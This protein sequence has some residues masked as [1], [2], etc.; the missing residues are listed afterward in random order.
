MIGKKY[1]NLISV[2]QLSHVGLCDGP[3][4]ISF[5]ILPYIVVAN[6]PIHIANNT[7]TRLR[8]KL[9]YDPAIKEQHYTYTRG[10]KQ[11]TI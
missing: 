3:R 9:E 10:N 1:L 6:P 4:G 8:M 11:N 5:G 7:T 2:P